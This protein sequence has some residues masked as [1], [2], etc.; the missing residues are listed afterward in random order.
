[1][2]QDP[3]DQVRV[4]DVAV[5]YTWRGSADRRA[6]LIFLHGLGDSS[7]ITF[8]RVAS[9]PALKNQASLLLDLPGFGYSSAP[10]AWP[11]TIELHADVVAQV[12]GSLGLSGVSIIGHSMGGSV[13]IMVASRTPHLVSRLILA[14]PLLRSEQSTLGASIS[15]RSEDA[16]VERGFAMLRLATHRQAKRG[17]IAAQSFQAPLS[18]ANP[19]T[20]HQSAS[21]LLQH[22]SP[23]FYELLVALDTPYTLV[24]GEHT[25]IAKQ[26]PLEDATTVIIP[27]A[28]HSM[29][30]EN[31]D[32]FAN[33]IADA[34]IHEAHPG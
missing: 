8:E 28:G 14:E 29:M 11:A 6:P 21:S 19:R 13:A 18:R 3:V 4:N 31:P 33:A 23:S 30:S 25:G 12:C 16:F 20:M 27:G 24:I 32:V 1:M 2:T 34:L 5:A 15:K 7:I 17:D 26:T 9:H 22:R 10:D